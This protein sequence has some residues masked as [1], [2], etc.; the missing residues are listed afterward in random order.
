MEP[1]E[2]AVIKCSS[3]GADMLYDPD[4]GL[5]RCP[6]C[7][8]ERSVEKSLPFKRDFYKERYD[9]EVY[10]GESSYQ[11]PNCGGSIELQNFAIATVCPFCGAT[12]IEKKEDMRGLKPDSILPFA[13]SRQKALEAGKKWLK[14]KLFAPSRLK[15]EF[16]FEKFN[17]V[18]FPTFAFSS[19][20]YSSYE[21][22]LGERR[23][24]VVGT[25]K[26]KRVETYIY[27]YNVS[28]TSDN[29]FR[30]VMIEA[31][32]R[33]KQKEL[34]KLSPFDVRTAESYKREY[35][36]GFFAERYGESLDDSFENAKTRMDA[37]IKRIIL[38]RYRADVVDHLNVSTTY[39]EVKFNYILLP[40]W[41]CGYRYKN[42]DY[43]FLVN[44][45]TGKST[46]KT[47]LSSLK[48]SFCAILSSGIVAFLVWLIGFSGIIQ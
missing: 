29:I 43:R 48:I 38:S 8:G 34:E 26:S 13:Y 30:D 40:I 24:R 11:C 21:G 25:G 14:R 47:P 44:G 17:G 42:R 4:K 36:A 18:Y 2:T 23:T 39:D 7:G 19:D 22:R 12:N 15:K 3:C 9:G 31:S 1:R 10:P 45:R 28:G 46:G 33:L 20:T 37:E 16:A 35:V 27:W 32:A 41:V 5:L 6:Y